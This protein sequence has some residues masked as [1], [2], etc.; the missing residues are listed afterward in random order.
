[1]DQNSTHMYPRRLKQ[2]LIEE[3]KHWA[4]VALIGPR[5][6]GKTTLAKEIAK[7][8]SS[9]YLDLQNQEDLDDITYPHPDEFC[10]TH[11]D[12]LIILDEIQYHPHLLAPIRK[13]ICSGHSQGREYTRFLLLGSA[14]EQLISQTS[15]P[16]GGRVR[17]IEI[18]GLSLLEINT[19]SSKSL[20]QLWFRGGF[21]HSYNAPSDAISYD[22]L[23]TLLEHHLSKHIPDQLKVDIPTAEL[24]LLLKFLAHHQGSTWNPAKT[25]T[26]LSVSQSTMNQCLKALSELR[27]VRSLR[28]W[29]KNEAKSLDKPPKV[30]FR[31]SGFVHTSLEIH[32]LD[33]L[34][35]PDNM[36]TGASWRGFVVE[37]ILSS[38][39]L[40]DKYYF[41]K[42]HLG[43]KI[44][45][46]LTFNAKNFW[47][48][49]IKASTRKPKISKGFY[50]ACE[51]L[52]VTRK[53]VIYRGTKTYSLKDQITLL[54]LLEF[55]KI[56]KKEKTL[57]PLLERLL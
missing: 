23:R 16:L 36:N 26:S 46:L 18:S 14:A 41:Y 39:S 15:L 5:S 38:F 35:H 43:N 42:N 12:K 29:F 4:I 49:E 24:N 25:A 11:Q 48:I 10:K 2:V 28:P 57:S 20:H 47:A 6:T 3:L 51:E 1:M 54:P 53:F 50:R 31:D 21:P 32:S 27:L 17:F 40:E 7:D 56:I 44:D 22:R 19:P 45:L 9:I 37:Q 34:L 52:P 13:I 55:M 30:Y 33:D 8:I